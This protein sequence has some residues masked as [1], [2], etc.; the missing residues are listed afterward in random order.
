[1]TSAISHLTG[2]FNARSFSD[3]LTHPLFDIGELIACA[4]CSE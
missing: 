2:G 1:M 3:I 4:L